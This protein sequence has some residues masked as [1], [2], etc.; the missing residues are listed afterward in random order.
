WEFRDHTDKI[1]GA[2]RGKSRWAKLADVDD[3]K[4]LKEG[5][6]DMEGDHVQSWVESKGGGWTADQHFLKVVHKNKHQFRTTESQ[7]DYYTRTAPYKY[8]RY[9]SRHTGIVNS[10]DVLEHTCAQTVPGQ[11]TCIHACTTEGD[12]VN[13]IPLGSPDDVQG[14]T[15]PSKLS[16]HFMVLLPNYYKPIDL[17]TDKAYHA[18]LVITKNPIG[19]GTLVAPQPGS[20]SYKGNNIPYLQT[21]AFD[22]HSDRRAMRISDEVEKKWQWKENTSIGYHIKIVHQDNLHA[23][24]FPDHPTLGLRLSDGGF[25]QVLSYL[26]EE[27]DELELRREVRRFDYWGRADAG[28]KVKDMAGIASDPCRAIERFD[29]ISS[30][31]YPTDIALALI[32]IVNSSEDFQALYSLQRSEDRERA[33]MT[34]FETMDSILLPR[35][36][37]FATEGS[38]NVTTPATLDALRCVVLHKSQVYLAS[39]PGKDTLVSNSSLHLDISWLEHHRKSLNEPYDLESLASLD[40]QLEYRLQFMR[41]AD[42]YVSALGLTTPYGDPCAKWD[43]TAPH[44]ARQPSSQRDHA[45]IRHALIKSNLF[46]KSRAC[47]GVRRFKKPLAYLA[48]AIQISDIDEETAI[49][50]LLSLK[51]KVI[52]AKAEALGRLETVEE[53]GRTYLSALRNLHR[54]PGSPLQ[55]P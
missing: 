38:L 25:E 6:D 54:S 17:Q 50:E 39:F 32:S 18:A 28:C 15:G 40:T 41:A 27:D 47:Q 16:M 30:T 37:R 46:P 21:L 55:S 34:F 9:I 10:P 8:K 29:N 31:I 20:D 44:A 36:D 24:I 4:F 2:V 35:I 3:D 33:L 49:Q 13:Y 52:A 23:V 12:I 11:K 51:K 26:G 43:G 5:F 19:P 14:D 22:A 42:L 48:T 53:A 1:F 7:L 45:R